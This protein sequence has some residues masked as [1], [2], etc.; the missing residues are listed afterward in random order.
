M[1]PQGHGPPQIGLEGPGAQHREGL[2]RAL[3]TFLLELLFHLFIL[4]GIIPNLIF[5]I[6]ICW[7][8]QKSENLGNVAS[9]L[10]ELVVSVERE[11]RAGREDLLVPID[12]LLRALLRRQPDDEI[13]LVFGATAD[14]EGADAGR[15]CEGILQHLGWFETV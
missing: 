7:F 11:F 5:F 3:H 14:L 15:E 6:F 1:L 8:F 2:V 12:H 10:R 9:A 4:N 13:R